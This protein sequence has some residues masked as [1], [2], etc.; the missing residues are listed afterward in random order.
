MEET[1]D[2]NKVVSLKAEKMFHISYI[3]KERLYL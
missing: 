3:H 2:K 1:G